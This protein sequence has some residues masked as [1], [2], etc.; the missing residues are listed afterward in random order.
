MGFPTTLLI[1]F[2]IYRGYYHEPY[3]I[4]R[5]MVI[6]SVKITDGPED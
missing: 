1:H 6:A 2:V 3:I 4:G 5:K